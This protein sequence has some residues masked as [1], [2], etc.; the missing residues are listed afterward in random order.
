MIKRLTLGLVALFAIIGSFSGLAANSPDFLYLIWDGNNWPAPIKDNADQ[1]TKLPKV[2]DGIYEAKVTSERTQYYR[3]WFA[4]FTDLADG[5]GSNVSMWVQNRLSPVGDN[6]ENEAVYYKCS[7]TCAVTAYDYNTNVDQWGKSFMGDMGTSALIRVDMNKKRVYCIPDYAE[8]LVVD[9]QKV[10]TLETVTEYWALKSQPK[11]HIPE[12]TLKMSIFNLF[13]NKSKGGDAEYDGGYSLNLNT[14]EGKD[15]FTYENWP[16]GVIGTSVATEGDRY[17]FWV[18]NLKKEEESLDVYKDGYIVGDFCSWD[19]ADEVPLREVSATVLE[20]EVPVGAKVFK[21]TTIGWTHNFGPA[22]FYGIR[23]DSEGNFYAYPESEGRNF[24]FDSPNTE[25]VIL[26]IN[27]E[28]G[29]VKF[30]KNALFTSAGE[31]YVPDPEVSNKVYLATP[32]DNIVDLTMANDKIVAA[33]HSELSMQPDGTYT[34]TARMRSGLFSFNIIKSLG[35]TPGKTV[36]V[37]PADDGILTTDRYKVVRRTSEYNGVSAPM[38]KLDTDIDDANADIVYNPATQEVTV[39][40]PSLKPIDTSNPE[41]I[42][43]IGSPQSWD[44]NDGSLQLQYMSDGK[45]YGE[46]PISA[47]MNNFRFYTSLGNW[48]DESSIGSGVYDFEE[49]E[50][51]FADGTYSWVRGNGNWKLTAEAAG[52]LYVSL[53]Y[54]GRAVRMSNEPI[55]HGEPATPEQPNKKVIYSD[56]DGR[57][58]SISN[59]ESPAASRIEKGDKFYIFDEM[60]EYP[61][62]DPRCFESALVLK[63]VNRDLSAVGVEGVYEAVK[64][65]EGMKYITTEGVFSQIII[66]GDIVYLMKPGCDMGAADFL[67]FDGEELP[68]LSTLEKYA[69]RMGIN[70]SLMKPVEI[71]AG[72]KG[73]QICSVV[74]N[75]YDS[76]CFETDLDFGKDAVCEV[77]NWPQG[78]TNHFILHNADGARIIS[79]PSGFVNLNALEKIYFNEYEPN[80][81]GT[82]TP[83][84]HEVK[85]TAPGSRVFEGTLPMSTYGDGSRGISATFLIDDGFYIGYPNTTMLINSDGDRLINSRGDYGVKKPLSLNGWSYTASDI[86]DGSLNFRVDLNDMTAVFT[87][88]EARIMEIKQVSLAGSEG[89]EKTSLGSATAFDDAGQLIS[90]S[91]LAPQDYT[92]RIDNPGSSTGARKPRYNRAPAARLTFDKYGICETEY[93]PAGVNEWNVSVTEEGSLKIHLNSETRKARIFNE[94]AVTGYYVLK[95]QTN[96]PYNCY[97]TPM[98]ETF[99]A[100]KA[101]MLFPAADGLY[102][103]EVEITRGGCHISI[104]S[105][106]SSGSGFYHHKGIFPYADCIDLYGMAKDD[107]REVSTLFVPGISNTLLVSEGDLKVAMEYDPVSY[108]LRLRSLSD[109][110]VC[111]LPVAEGVSLR[112]ADGGVAVSADEETA[113]VAYTLQGICTVRV[114]VPAGEEVI[115][116]LA[117]GVYVSNLGK[118]IV[119]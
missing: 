38:W 77:A 67:V 36:V 32:G 13:D 98:I 41:K 28:T 105:C 27:L 102:K 18:N 40:I 118:F 37:G 51:P 112:V 24:E 95:Y 114:T 66:D 73:F 100:S 65:G 70:H 107:E 46:I 63:P 9:G 34:C 25:P 106:I 20:A 64:E 89:S 83:I 23:S 116:P 111:N 7:A 1:M 84:R 10:P 6:A 81:Q 93:N 110:G 44:I 71:P 54:N 108:T 86:K 31:Y 82:S 92:L 56:I 61:V 48:D 96:L 58:Y 50:I 62:S 75:N 87:P 49:V 115:V 4:I 17:C 5:D 90:F 68:T 55:A 43:V 101:E 80:P 88:V 47:G 72:A 8:Y 113:F 3:F 85:E 99:D 11:Y 39:T 91:G 78:G 69:S 19:F 26:T 2:A 12:G 15:T 53:D 109:S 103:G 79:G 29:L 42:Y 117:K 94:S 76:G 74:K 33:T 97:Y 104:G 35:E 16:G 60:P 119:R 14:A 52:T 59:E 22:E 30:S 57:F 21:V 45:Y